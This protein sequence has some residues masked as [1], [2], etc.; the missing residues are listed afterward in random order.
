M[1]LFTPRSIFGILISLTFFPLGLLAQGT[2][3]QSIWT[4][5]SLHEI[6]SNETDEPQI[7]AREADYFELDFATL[8]QEIIGAPADYLISLPDGQGDFNQFLLT[9]NTTMHP[10][11]NEKF[12]EIGSFNIISPESRNTWGK[13]DISPS[14]LRVM[15]FT[16]GTPTMFIDPVFKGNDIYY[17]AYFKNHFYTDKLAICHVVSESDESYEPASPKS[18]PYNE[19]ELKTYRLAV[20]ATGEYSIFHGG[21]VELAMAAI[22]TTMNRVNGVYE[23]DFGVTMTLIPNNDVIVYTNPASDPFTNGNAGAMLQENQANTNS[24]IGA[25][26]Y[27]IGH[28]FGT[29]SGG[30]AGL[31]VTCNNNNK[32]RGVTGSSAPV[33]DPFDIDY[34]AHEIGHQFG[35]NHSFNN[36][37]G[38]NR[39]NSTAME[40]GSGSTIMAYAGICPTNVQNNSDDH[41]HGVNMREIGIQIT[42]NGCQVNS[43]TGNNAPVIGVLPAEIFIPVNTPFALTADVTDA[44]GDEL[45]YNWEQMDNEI[46]TQPPLASSTGGPNFRS[47][48]PTTNPT[49]YFPRLSVV[50]SNGPFT[51]ERLPAFGRDMS[52]R[53]SVRDNAPIAGCTQ[54]ADIDVVVVPTAGPFQV[55]YPSV[56]GI[57]WQGFDYETVTWDVANTTSSPINADL[58]DIF[59]STNGGQSYPLLLAEGVPNTGSFPLMVP[60]IGTT[61]ARIMVMNSGGTFFDVSNSNFSIEVIENGFYFQA[62]EQT[63]IICQGDEFSFSFSIEEVGSFE[64]VVD[65]SVSAQPA[66]TNVVL[67]SMVA[68]VGD[69]ITVTVTGTENSPAVIDEIVITGE[70]DGFSNDFS[71]VTVIINSNPIASTPVSPENASE[72]V[73]TE[74]DLVWENNA[75][76]GVTYVLEVSTD[77]NFNDLIANAVGL[78]DT[79]FTVS[80]LLPETTYYWRIANTSTCGFSGPSNSFSFTTFVCTAQDGDDL[81]LEIESVSPTTITSEIEVSQEGIVADVN[82]RNIEGQHTRI[83]DLIFSLTSPSGT[84]VLLTAANCGLNI[85]LGSNGDVV[86]NSPQTIS[87]VYGSSG[88]AAFGPNIPAGGITAAAVLA[89]DGSA[90][91]A[92]LCGPAI[93]A[94]ELNGNIAIVRRGECPF[95]EKVINAQNAGATAV[96]VINNVAGGV[97]AMG[98]TSNQINIPSVMITQANGNLF[99]SETG[100]DAENF[101][102]GFDDQAAEGLIS[103]P[104]TSGNSFQPIGLLSAF[105]GEQSAGTWTLNITDVAPGNGGSLDGWELQ[106]CLTGEEFVSVSNARLSEIEIYPNPTT[107]TVWIDFQNAIFD[108][109]RIFDLQGRQAFNHTVSGMNRINLDLSGYTNGMYIVHLEGPNG[110]VVEKIMKLE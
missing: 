94:P 91:G 63:N 86:V 33:N 39:N 77:L 41:F 101:F 17:M 40:P 36:A 6:L 88:A 49:G 28:V 96:I 55:I 107:S 105:N 43:Q 67:S 35:G 12:P 76:I 18:D 24:V 92:E 26:N 37:C 30:V 93:N 59:L 53:L 100:T 74:V 38:G 82:V 42:Q 99:L 64:G 54:Y 52:F 95:V 34:V 78:N 65:L 80:N 50:A 10:E 45:T 11:L 68:G 22:V 20:A 57:T 110:V 32:A 48:S 103:C 97:I 7:F 56:A 81:P 19:C 27:D 23:R 25:A 106:I 90:N 15:I 5:N 51:W 89:D 70:A 71:F 1:N 98:G 109:I 31:G 46:S 8:Y 62:D 29:N 83:T 2:S 13:L 47:F 14:G 72:G 16:P 85:T 4:A 108:Q 66:N 102:F 3:G 84:E 69:E 73:S 75:G 21:T 58:V 104:A 87:G 61:T 60:N 9:A 44:D 79:S